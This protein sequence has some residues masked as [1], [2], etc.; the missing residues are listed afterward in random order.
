MVDVRHGQMTAMEAPSSGLLGRDRVGGGLGREKSAGWAL[1]ADCDEESREL[2]S[3]LGGLLV[4]TTMGEG[5]FLVK[6]G[7]M[8]G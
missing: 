2:F 7:W 4:R 6:L 8:E 1:M 3:G 5:G